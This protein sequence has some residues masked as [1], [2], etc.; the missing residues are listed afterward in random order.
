[1]RPPSL[2]VTCR[3]AFLRWG[4][5]R[6]P[7]GGRGPRTAGASSAERPVFGP[8][9]AKVRTTPDTRRGPRVLQNGGVYLLANQKGCD[10][11]RLYYDGCAMVAMNGRVFAQGAQFSLA[12]VV[13]SPRA[14]AAGS[15]A[16]PS[17]PGS[18]SQAA[19]SVPAITRRP[20]PRHPRLGLSLCGRRPRVA[21]PRGHR[22]AAAA[23]A[24][25]LHVIPR[26]KRG[27]RSRVSF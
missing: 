5:E 19:F 15:R 23:P 14:P 12:D 17:R 22:V 1:M 11:D 27:P 20:L 21:S 7:S 8:L 16:G 25:R 10:G 9:E 13:R 6:G 3:R 4:R 2:P 24:S 18:R 26:Q